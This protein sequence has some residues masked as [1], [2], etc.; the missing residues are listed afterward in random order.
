LNRLLDRDSNIISFSI[1]SQWRLALRNLAVTVAMRVIKATSAG[2][3][4]APEDVAFLRAWLASEQRDRP[5]NELACLVIE[6]DL[7]R[8]KNAKAQAVRTAADT[9]NYSEESGVSA[10]PL[11]IDG[12]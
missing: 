9:D 12:V 4:G 2:E 7:R 11:S 5:T 10:G 8:R 6:A 3:A 1:F